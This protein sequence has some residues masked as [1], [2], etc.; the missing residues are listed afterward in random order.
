MKK[1]L[2]TALCGLVLTVGAAQA[3]AA[4]LEDWN[5][6][7]EGVTITGSSEHSST[8]PDG[9]FQ[10]GNNFLSTGSLIPAQTSTGTLTLADTGTGTGAATMGYQNILQFTTSDNEY[11]YDNPKGLH[12]V[13][14]LQFD[15]NVV[16]AGDEISFDLTYKIPFWYNIFTDELYYDT[17]AAG[18][19]N[20]QGETYTPLASNGS[21]NYY[22]SP[23]GLQLNGDGFTNGDYQF[24]SIDHMEG[25]LDYL[26]TGSFTL[27]YTDTEFVPPNPTPEPATMLL[28]G[29]GLAGLGRLAR[30]RKQK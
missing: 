3:D 16:S 18:Y 21:Y 20:A 15:F 28:T 8:Y 24:V 11:I 27:S 14:T 23:I 22:I 10:F 19:L 30:R 5:Y 2:G 9:S 25:G 1:L 26:L 6:N 7:L 4:L 29:L 12:E 13:F 17:A